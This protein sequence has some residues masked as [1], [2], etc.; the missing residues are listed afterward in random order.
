MIQVKIC[1]VRTIEHAQAAVEAGADMLGLVFAPSRRR[2]EPEHAR[3]I[4]ATIRASATRP[5][6][7]VGLFV[8]EQSEHIVRTVEQCGLDAI[9]LSGDEDLEIIEHLPEVQI[10][11]AVRLNGDAREQAW[12][13]NGMERLT[14]LVD[15]HVPGNYGGTGVVADWKRAAELARH[16]RVLLAGG[17]NAANVRSAIQ[18]VQPWGVD[19]SSGVET[20]GQKDSAKIRQFVMVARS[21]KEIQ[22]R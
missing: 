16:R 11:K 18:E 20:D 12:L 17:L 19:V 14:L 10:I 1:G 6:S 13:S 7:F 4:V 21:N 22:S 9:Q 5:P 2:I 3:Q 8:N 15:A